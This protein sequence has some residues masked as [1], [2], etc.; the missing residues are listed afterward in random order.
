LFL[1]LTK[2]DM[3][4][5]A[6]RSDNAKDRWDSRVEEACVDFWARGHG[7]W[8]HNWGTKARPFTNLFW[9]RN[10][11]ADQMQAL[12]PGDAD[13]ETVKQGYLASRAVATYIAQPADKWA[14][15]EG[16]E[17]PSG[18]PKSGVP[19]L[20]THLRQKLAEDIKGK[21]LTQEARAIRSEL[22]SVL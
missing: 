4:L 10:P 11:Y 9:I 2:F 6:L 16:Y 22:L 3:S 19:L 7:S 21:E 18:L 12:K 13:Y 1:A 15:V 20:A 8:L 14:A 17:T 5:G